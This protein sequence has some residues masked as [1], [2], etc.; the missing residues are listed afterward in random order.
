MKVYNNIYIN[1]YN[2]TAQHITT[3]DYIFIFNIYSKDLGRRAS[4]VLNRCSTMSTPGGGDKRC[5]TQRR[6][7]FAIRMAKGGESS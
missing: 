4:A 7:V 3:N 5:Y 2:N 6:R 1:I